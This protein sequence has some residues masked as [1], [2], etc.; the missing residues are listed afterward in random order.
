MSEFINHWGK[1][2]R[3]EIPFRSDS[4]FSTDGQ[5]FLSERERKRGDG[6]RAV[7][8]LRE[9]CATMSALGLPAC[10]TLTFF[11]DKWLDPTLE[12]DI[13]SGGTNMSARERNL[14]ALN[15][16]AKAYTIKATGATFCPEHVLCAVM[17]ELSLRRRHP[18]TMAWV[19]TRRA[20]KGPR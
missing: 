5:P 14:S 9:A 2:A 12:R 16:A 15:T 17:P 11:R 8:A 3:V 6:A 7:E 13:F 4:F 19:A 18:A 1:S 10:P 20:P